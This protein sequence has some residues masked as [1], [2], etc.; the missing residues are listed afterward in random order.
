MVGLPAQD[1]ADEVT[2]DL[3]RPDLQKDACPVLIHP[4][5][6][7][8]E[9]DRMAQ[10][11][12][13]RLPHVRVPPGKGSGQIV[14][15]DR[16]GRRRAADRFQNLLELSCRLLDEGGVKTAADR[17]QPGLHLAG[18]QFG[19][20]GNQALAPSGDDGLHRRVK[21]GDVDFLLVLEHLL[22]GF[23]RTPDRHHGPGVCAGRS[24]HAGAARPEQ[25]VEGLLLEHARGA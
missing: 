20:Q 1:L 6:L 25:L 3:P 22:H 17:E 2:A 13:Q 16:P 14:R 7:F 19:L 5:D 10:V 23:P 4:L 12:A 18:R 15:I 11:G 9:P 8:H 21:V 24:K